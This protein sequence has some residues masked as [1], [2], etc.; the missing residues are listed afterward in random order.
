MVS[1]I[2]D[3]CHQAGPDQSCQQQM[4]SIY[5]VIL[6]FSSKLMSSSVASLIMNGTLCK[7]ADSLSGGHAPHRNALFQQD[8][9]TYRVC[10]VVSWSPCFYLVANI[11][12]WP[13]C[14]HHQGENPRAADSASIL[15]AP[16]PS[17]RPC[18]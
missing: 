17:G 2:H 1:A 13:L 16:V 4:P 5:Y 18:C 9:L 11:K 6:S 14:R 3:C 7:L 12:E 15:P 10:D 8:V